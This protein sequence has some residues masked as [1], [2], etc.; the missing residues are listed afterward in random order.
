M[1]NENQENVGPR[2]KNKCQI[3]NLI[4]LYG[5]NPGVIPFFLGT[6][7]FIRIPMEIARP[8]AGGFST[9]QIQV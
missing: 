6:A 2:N 5:G 8:I 7:W 3:I 1:W 4:Y 9:K